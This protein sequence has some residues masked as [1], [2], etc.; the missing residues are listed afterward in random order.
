[1]RCCLFKQLA[2]RFRTEIPLRRGRLVSHF[3]WSGSNVWPSLSL[4]TGLTDFTG[5]EAIFFAHRTSSNALRIQSR[6]ISGVFDPDSTC[7]EVCDG[8]TDDSALAFLYVN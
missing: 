4:Y 8:H 7:L 2:E 5:L 1:M 3:F 6:S